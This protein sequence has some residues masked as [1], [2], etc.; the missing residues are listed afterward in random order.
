MKN[1]SIEP[2]E[3]NFNKREFVKEEAFLRAQKKVKDMEG[4]YWHA[5]VYFIIN[6]FLII[7]IG[8]NSESFWHFGVFATPFFWG[9]GLFFHYMSVFGKDLIFGKNWEER[10]I[11][12]Y[13]DKDREE[14]RKFQ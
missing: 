2:Y 8:V 14:Q 13:M 5:T 7:L 9:I 10:K 11:K 3:D 1:S 6:L 4:F 12:E